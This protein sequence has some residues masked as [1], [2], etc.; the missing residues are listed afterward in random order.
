MFADVSFQ[1][2]PHAKK[3]HARR[4]RSRPASVNKWISAPDISTGR[5]AVRGQRR[6][7]FIPKA[8]QY[9]AQHGAC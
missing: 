2:F 1:F 6:F 9:T 5:F 4:A 3:A 8:L 7:I